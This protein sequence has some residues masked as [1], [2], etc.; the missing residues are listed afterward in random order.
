MQRIKSIFVVAVLSIVFNTSVF[1]SAENE[2]LAAVVNENIVLAVKAAKPIAD[3]GNAAAQYFLSVVFLN[4]Y[5]QNG[6]PEVEKDLGQSVHYLEMYVNNINTSAKNLP[7]VLEK[8]NN[9]KALAKNLPVAFKSLSLYY[10]TV[11]TDM[12]KGLK[13]MWHAGYLGDEKSIGL[14]S[15]S[16]CKDET[17]DQRASCQ[18]GIKNQIKRCPYLCENEKVALTVRLAKPI[19]DHGNAPAQFLLSEILG[20]GFHQEGQKEVEMDTGQAIH[21]LEMYVNNS[22]ALPKNLPVAFRVLG[23]HYMN[24]DPDKSLK[25]MWHAGYLGDEV[26]SGGLSQAVCSDQSRD[27]QESCQDRIKGQ[28]KRC[29]YMCQ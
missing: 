27:Q 4:G 14:L 10:M 5:H 13:Y 16:A 6:Q 1:A 17:R 11:D 8:Y 29:P 28:I 12:E 26:S 23:V 3:N 22:K 15:V 20:N 19:A 9:G 2:M 18:Q 25:Y 21:Y 7:A 24:T